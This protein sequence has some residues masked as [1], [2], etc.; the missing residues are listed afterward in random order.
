[1]K[2]VK[3]LLLF[4]LILSGCSKENNKINVCKFDAP[5]STR[6]SF[7]G[8]GDNLIHGSI[9]T[10]SHKEDGSY[11]FS[12]IYENI[13]DDV[14]SKD[15]AFIN[16]ETPIGGESLGISGYPMFNSPTKLIENIHDVG[17]NLVNLATN[18]A[19]DRSEKAIINELESFKKYPDMIFDGV[20][21]SQEAF[22]TIPTF[23]MKGIT[24]SFLAYTYGTNG[25]QAPHSY[26]VS[27]L[28]EDQIRKDVKIAKEISDVIIVSAHWGSEN[29]FTVSSSQKKYAQLFA[30]LG[31]DVVIGTHPHVLQ[32]IEW[33]KGVNGNETLVAY[34]LGNFLGGMLGVNNAVSGMIQFDFVKRNNEITIEN[35]SWLPLFIHF[36][37]YGNDIVDDRNNY[38]IYKVSEYTDE[39]AKKHAL[40]GYNGQKV[41][42]EYIHSITNKIIDSDYLE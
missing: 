30:D 34:S 3:L 18:H 39:L 2:L 9:N 41:S 31:V 11:D 17:F 33:V 38:K 25:I 16:Q 4:I 15:I 19:L 23:E 22:D 40:N 29:S 6:V 14:Q 10:S 24:F 35:I 26:N 20:Y 42:L 36:E 27:Y 13:V 37:R 12:T 21:T 7:V 28:N 8:V 1:M 32:P 5:K